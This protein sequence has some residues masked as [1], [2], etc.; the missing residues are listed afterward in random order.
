MSNDDPFLSPKR[1][2]LGQDRRSNFNGRTIQY[3]THMQ[4]SLG[5]GRI[6]KGEEKNILGFTSEGIIY[7]GSRTVH[8]IPDYYEVTSIGPPDS[9]YRRYSLVETDYAL[10]ITEESLQELSYYIKRHSSLQA[11]EKNYIELRKE[12]DK[13]EQL[14]KDNPTLA[15]AWK[16]YQTL[17]NMIA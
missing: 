16:K 13:E 2:F 4:G 14:R 7:A 1:T 11:S 3:S 15:E 17:K 5:F 6:P 8:T 10:I 9:S 12:Q